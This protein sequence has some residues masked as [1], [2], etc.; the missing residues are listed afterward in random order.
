MLGIKALGW[1]FRGWG[2]RRYAGDY[3]L[4]LHHSAGFT[5]WGL[6]VLLG[7]NG[8]EL[9]CPRT[10]LSGATSLTPT[11]PPRSSFFGN[12]RFLLRFALCYVVSVLLSPLFRH[13]CFDFLS[14]PTLFLGD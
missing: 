4:G 9:W 10:P 14:G 13:V 1:E 2:L 3:G 11:H 7:I 8:L 5:C 12:S 6:G